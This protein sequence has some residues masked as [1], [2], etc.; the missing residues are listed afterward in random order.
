[1]EK[2]LD[3]AESYDRVAIGFWIGAELMLVGAAYVWLLG[4]GGTPDLI[5]IESDPA[6]RGV[7]V[8]VPLERLWSRADEGRSR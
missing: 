7:R 2:K 5:R 8:G 1:M 4:D 6:E 3:T